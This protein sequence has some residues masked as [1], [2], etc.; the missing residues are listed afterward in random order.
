VKFLA[1]KSFNLTPIA[2]HQSFM[3]TI[4]KIFSL[5][6]A[7]CLW[8]AAFFTFK[9][10]AQDL[11]T[12]TKL[13]KVVNES[14][15]MELNDKHQVWTLNDSGG[16]AELYL[17]DTTGR[18]IRTLKIA[19]AQNRDWEDMTQDDQG[20]YY[21]GDFGN[22]NN[23]RKDLT[24]YK[25]PNPDQVEASFVK[26]EKITFAFEDQKAFPPPSDQLNFDCE[27]VIWKDGYLYLFSKH[28]TF[29]MRTNLYR[30][31]DAPGDYV[32]KKISSFQTSGPDETDLFNHWIS[33]ADISPDGTK[34]CI[35]SSGKMW[36]FYNFEGDDFF[37]GQH[38]RI[39]LSSSSQREAVVFVSNTRVYLTD[40]EWFGG[41]GRNLYSI[42]IS[43]K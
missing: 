32:A 16:K 7:I 29:P 33:A 6:M 4:S 23:Q 37:S 17:C 30:L 1:K 2:M 11:Q 22:N 27:S 38:K 14:S 15:G 42:D 25:I 26:A 21:I 19:N 5:N 24:I 40:E 41:I 34:V 35:I 18:L 39:D 13:P 10:S 28:R 20:N 8:F 9:L 3:G 31:P 12:I 36:I 43:E